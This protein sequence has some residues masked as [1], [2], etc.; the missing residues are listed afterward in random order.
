MYSIRLASIEDCAGINSVSKYLGYTEVSIDECNDKLQHL[1]RSE[2]DEIYV[3][4]CKGVIIGW[5]HLFLARRIASPDF[6]EIGGLVVN[7]EFSRLGIGK[8]LVEH[9][10]NIQTGKFRVRCN[11][12]RRSSHLFYIKMGFIGEKVQRIFELRSK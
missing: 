8:V 5:L 2:T 4:V 10:L 6:Y 7:P 9:V 12:K 3:A 11:E 1:L